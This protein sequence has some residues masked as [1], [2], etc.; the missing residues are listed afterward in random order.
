MCREH[1]TT[2]GPYQIQLFSSY[3]ACAPGS[4]TASTYHL[5]VPDV[6]T[7]Q[8]EV[9]VSE[10]KEGSHVAV[11]LVDQEAPVPCMGFDLVVV[12]PLAG[13]QDEAGTHQ[14][15]LQAAVVV[16]EGGSPRT[17]TER[18]E[19]VAAWLRPDTRRPPMAASVVQRRDFAVG[20]VVAA[21][22]VQVHPAAVEVAVDQVHISVDILVAAEDILVA[23]DL[24][25]QLAAVS[26]NYGYQK[27]SIPVV[28]HLVH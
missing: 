16:V 26:M 25:A 7:G 15:V 27:V 17:G 18:E 1:P 11:A 8:S 6:P 2:S 3:F 28:G 22:V 9:P 19:V 20:V 4:S 21:A 12:V 14:P 10:E 23:L 13:L 5:L 24:V